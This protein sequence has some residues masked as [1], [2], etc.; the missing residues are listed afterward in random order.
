MSTETYRGRRKANSEAVHFRGYYIRSLPGGGFGI[1]RKSW[2]DFGGK[3]TPSPSRVKEVYSA[4]FDSSN[5]EPNSLKRKVEKSTFDTWLGLFGIVYCSD[6]RKDPRKENLQRAGRI[7]CGIPVSPDY[8]IT[9]FKKAVR[10]FWSIRMQGGQ[11][12]V[13]E[14]KHSLIIADFMRTEE[15]KRAY[16]FA[17]KRGG[18]KSMLSKVGY[19][20]IYPWIS[21]RRTDLSEN[22]RE[23]LRLELRRRAHKGLGLGSCFLATSP[24]KHERNLR[25]RVLSLGE[26]FFD[27]GGSDVE[28]D[29]VKIVKRLTGL[30][31]EVIRMDQGMQSK[32]ALVTERLTNF[33]IAWRLVLGLDVWGMKGDYIRTSQEEREFKHT[34]GNMQNTVFRSDGGVGL[35]AI[36]VKTG[37]TN[38]TGYLVDETH[39]K[40]AEN[41]PVW[42]SAPD[43]SENRELQRCVVF[44]HRRPGSYEKTIS[45]IESERVHVVGFPEIY[46]SLEETIGRL[47]EKKKLFSGLRPEI[48]DLG[49]IRALEKEISLNPFLIV[50]KGGDGRRNFLNHILFN[51]IIRAKDILE[52]RRERDSSSYVP[53]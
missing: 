23:E 25:R 52:S 8:N 19:K 7:Y 21:T 3:R 39:I 49:P 1:S 27:K 14:S 48:R 50:E 47:Q 6:N 46:S 5:Y 13:G 38:S 9:D 44:L 40:Y 53:F 2:K 10:V 11:P 22:S 18:F 32:A 4:Q 20:D 51:L 33:L 35:T 37:I 43:G 45:R 28:E 12:R 34:S 41:S 36:E 30:P 29:Y 15:G 31:E 17:A 24:S 26:S 16:N 42:L